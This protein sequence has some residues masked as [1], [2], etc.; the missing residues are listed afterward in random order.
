MKILFVVSE[1]TPFIKTGGLADVA[2]A[3]PAALIKSGV[4]IRVILPK[5]KLINSEFT[6]HLK[7]V[8]HFTVH[9]GWREQYCGIEEMQLN[10]VT[11]YFI[12]N[13][14]YFY[15]DY[16]Y[17]KPCK[18]ECE[19]FSFFNRA[20]LE[21]L[22][23]IGFFP[24][25]IHCNDW[26]TGMI[27]FLLKTD[28][29]EDPRYAAV[30]TV[31]TIHNLRFQGL[32]PFET[33]ADFLSI[34]VKYFTIDALEFYG[35]ASFMKAALKFSDKL[36]T[37]SKSYAKEILTPFFGEKLD[38]V[39]NE[40]KDDLVGILNGI[41][42]EIFNPATDSFLPENY[43]YDDMTGKVICKMELLREVGLKP[44]NAPIIAMVTRLTDQKGLDLVNHVLNGIL[45][46]GARL[47]ILGEGDERYARTIRAVC[48]ARPDD[49]VFIER[50]S[51]PLAHRIY[52]GA[53]IYLM[54]SLFEPCGL[55]QLI[56]MKYGTIPVVRETGGLLD[57]VK[58]YNRYNGV[59]NGFAFSNFNAYEMLFTLERAV[60]CMEYPE[61]WNSLIKSAM[62][63]D[64][65]FSNSAKLYLDLYSKL[66]N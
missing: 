62:N 53:D 8:A 58:P 60:R 48:E 29:A 40:R 38:G 41:S 44:G 31:F 28:Y 57:T 18:D 49:I 56:A 42:D 65:S 43:S 23:A 66:S 27:P 7:H 24:N 26:L 5:Y 54:P 51:E 36:T 4:D 50:Q 14:F 63:E 55:S 25:I 39:L 52:A 46:T 3:L 45:S 9:L 2:N 30:K 20:V 33:V 16:I 32:F 47:I 13:E 12:D 6:S 59:G 19:R 15:R 35:S 64:F 37:V 11:Y 22:P 61:I 17:A 10:G 34:D 21:A 1:A